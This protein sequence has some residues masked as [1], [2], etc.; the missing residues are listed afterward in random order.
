M[1][2]DELWILCA[3][4][5]VSGRGREWGERQARKPCVAEER[6]AYGNRPHAEQPSEGVFIYIHVYVVV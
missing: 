5:Y 3:K 4:G 2:P 6:L 1:N